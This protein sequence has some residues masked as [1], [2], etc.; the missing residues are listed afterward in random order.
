M[1]VS[2]GGDSDTLAC[3]TG[4]VAEAYYQEIPSFI[5]DKVLSLLPEEFLSLLKQLADGAYASCYA[6]YIAGYTPA[7]NREYTP[8]RI[9]SLKPGEVFVFGSNLAGH[10]GGGAARLAYERFG[11]KWGTGVG[12]TGQC[13]AIPTMQGASGTEP[14]HHAVNNGKHRN[15]TN[16]T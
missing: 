12:M 1:A 14:F 13:Y 6:K 3:I 8:D 15:C 4:A 10:H 7:K 2:M 5:A 11:A 9:S 16:H